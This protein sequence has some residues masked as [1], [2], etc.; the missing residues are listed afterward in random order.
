M[1]LERLPRIDK[2]GRSYFRGDGADRNIL[3]VEFAISV[4]KAV[5]VAILTVF[6]ARLGGACRLASRGRFAPFAGLLL[7]VASRLSPDTI[8]AFVDSYPGVT[9]HVAG[10]AA[11]DAVLLFE[12]VRIDVARIERCLGGD[13]GVRITLL[14]TCYLR[15]GIHH[16][17]SGIEPDPTQRRFS[18]GTALAWAARASTAEALVSPIAR[19]GA[20]IH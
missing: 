4:L 8:V 3:S 18:D 7:A 16:D 2:A 10:N 20:A 1:R 15:G 14:D 9:V 19:L 17:G 11:G 12:G 6:D 13:A 5:H